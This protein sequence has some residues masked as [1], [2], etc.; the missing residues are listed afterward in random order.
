MAAI[1]ASKLRANFYRVLDEV[2]ATGHPAVIGRR[3]KRLRIVPEEPGGR[4]SR[5]PRWPGLLKG[6]PEDIVHMD[7][8]QYWKPDQNL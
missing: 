7:W 4:L 8:S 3:G 5:L 2:L 6:D 1:P